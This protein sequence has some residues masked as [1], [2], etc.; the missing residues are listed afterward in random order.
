MSNMRDYYQAWVSDA[1]KEYREDFYKRSRF[2]GTNPLRDN[3]T[4]AELCKSISAHNPKSILEIGC[5]YG[6]LLHP[7]TIFFQ[8]LAGVPVAGCDVSDDMIS[9][10]SNDLDV[11]HWDI[12]KKR[13]KEVRYEDGKTCFDVAYSRGVFMYF[14]KEQL[15][16]AMKHVSEIV[17]KAIL[18]YEWEWVCTMM[19]RTFSQG[20]FEYHYI[21]Q[22]DE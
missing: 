17:D 7:V 22:E 19:K 3:P 15:W 20:N 9:L 1:G 2:S 18:I 14:T 21:E 8:E 4:V 11:F 13:L 5:G 12:Y 16:T 10:C 6:R